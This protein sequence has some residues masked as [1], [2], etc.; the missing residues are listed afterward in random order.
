MQN[1]RL[2]LDLEFVRHLAL[3]PL[4]AGRQRIC[5]STSE[6]RA[7]VQR[8]QVGEAVRSGGPGPG[9]VGARGPPPGAGSPSRNRTAP[10][11]VWRHRI[12]ASTSNAC[13]VLGQLDVGHRRASSAS[14]SRS[15]KRRATSTGT[16]ES[17]APWK[18][19]IG[20]ADGRHPAVGRGLL[21]RPRG[22]RRAETFMTCFSRK[23]RSPGP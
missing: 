1:A 18:T 5:D 16:S 22:G 10:S 6:T 9:S 23:R 14:R 17:F 20:G 19:S 3:S 7:G 15:T 11:V 4:A 13:W 12:E 21:E 2:P 8:S